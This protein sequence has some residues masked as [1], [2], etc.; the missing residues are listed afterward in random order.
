MS[1]A[2]K[3]WIKT[4]LYL[5]K[6]NSSGY[7]ITPK[8]FNDFLD[9]VVT[10]YF[11]K[12]F[13]VYDAYGQ[14]QESDKTITKQAT[15]VVVLVHENTQKNENNISTV[16]SKYRKQFQNPDVMRTIS[17]IEVQFYKK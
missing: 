8:Q 1:K 13:T 14:I 4:E 6:D 15:W 9:K 17:P 10:K 7:E 2:G 5:G 3:E 11:P 12:G 16:I